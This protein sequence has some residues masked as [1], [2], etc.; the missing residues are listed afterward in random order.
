MI[1]C[2]GQGKVLIPPIPEPAESEPISMTVYHNKK[3]IVMLIARTYI[4]KQSIMPIKKGDQIYFEGVIEEME[5]GCPAITVTLLRM[6]KHN[7]FY[8]D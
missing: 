5:E 7:R 4:M 1:K 3:H 2:R 8:K 6:V